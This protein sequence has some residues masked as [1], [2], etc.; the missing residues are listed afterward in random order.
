MQIAIDGPAGA[1]KSTIAKII[2]KE[3]NMLY[4]DTGAM[5]RAVTYGVLKAG[6]AWND[7]SAITQVAL[8]SVIDF[9]GPKVFLNGEDVSEVIRTPEVS[10]NIFHVADL[11]AVREILVDQQR[12]IAGETSVIMDGRDIA[13]VVLPNADIKIFLDADVEERARRRHIELQAKGIEKSFDDIK[14]EIAARDEADRSRPVGALICV[15]DAIVVDTTGKSIE[16][17]CE[18]IQGIIREHQQ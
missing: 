6:V 8:Q 11:P 10:K 2:A 17:V 5:Y 13:S 9:D 14:S 18:I 1:G 7:A 4:L 12:R 3:N 15:P 16:E